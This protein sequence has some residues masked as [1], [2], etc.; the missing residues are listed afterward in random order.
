MF[1]EGDS[2]VSGSG[3]IVVIVEGGS[4]LVVVLGVVEVDG[5]TS[6]VE[7]GGVVVGSVVVV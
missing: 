1:V 5:S 3:M 7:T 6:G 4:V 2:V